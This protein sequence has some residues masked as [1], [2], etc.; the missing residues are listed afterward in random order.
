MLPKESGARF[1]KN[2]TTNLGKILRKSYEVSKIGPL[3]F[4][5][6]WLTA[7]FA[8]VTENECIND[9]H[10]R[11]NEYI[12]YSS[13]LSKDRSSRS[14]ATYISAPDTP[15]SAVSLRQLIYLF[16]DASLQG[17]LQTAVVWISAEICA[18][19]HEWTHRLHLQRTSDTVCVHLQKNMESSSFNGVVKNY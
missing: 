13:V 14:T 19:Y 9:R 18:F 11:D 6:I 3:I 8:D 16:S 1:S 15:C 12:L 10:L 5:N 4:C 17:I 2:L 7:I